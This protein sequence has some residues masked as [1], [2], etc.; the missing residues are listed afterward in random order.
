[1]STIEQNH[2]G[3]GDN[4]SG[5]KIYKIVKALAPDD[6]VGPLE[7]VFESLRKRDSV[8]AKIQIDM[9]RAMVHKE[10]ESVALLD[11]IAIYGSLID[12]NDHDSAWGTVANTAATTQSS[13]VKD[14][15]LAA[16]LRL[17]HGTD[18]EQAAKDHYLGEATPGQYA[19]EVF[20][21]QY[22]DEAYIKE[23]S[24]QFLISEASL[25]G[26]V[27]GSLRL[28]L[29][30][31]ANSMALRLSRDYPSY[32]AKVLQVFA[33]AY[34]LNPYV[35]ERH[36]WLCT[37]D[38]KQKVDQ[39]AEQVVEL[40]GISGDDK[41]L[42]N[43]ACPVFEAYRGMAPPHLLQALQKNINILEESHS[44]VAAA[45]KA[46]SGNDE[47]ISERL[48]G[49]LAAK[50]TPRDR[51][52]WCNEFLSASDYHIEDIFPFF[53][54]ATDTEIDEWLSRSPSIKNLSEVEE[55]LVILLGYSFREKKSNS[56][57][58]KRKHQL[59]EKADAFLKQWEQEL[60]NFTPEWIFELAENLILSDLP[61]KAIHFTSR[62]VPD[63]SLW[64]SPFVL[65][66]LRGL[67]EA[68]QYETF[69]NIIKKISDPDSSIS[70]LNFQSLKAER[71]GDINSAIAIS[72]DILGRAPETPYS[73]HRGCFLRSRHQ[74]TAQQ[75]DF[76][77]TIPDS[78]LKNYSPDALRILYFLTFSGNFKRAESHWVE[79]FIEDPKAR[80]VELVNFH[81]GLTADKKN[82]PEIVTSPQLLQC[83]AA[84]HFDQDGTSMTRLIVKDHQ[85]S[86]EFTLKSSSQLAQLLQGMSVGCSNELGMVSYTLLEKLDP[87]VACLRI[88]LHLRTIQNDGS[89][90]F[91]MLTIPSAQEELVPYLEKKL[92]PS[93]D[94]RGQLER[95]DL[96]LYIRGNFLYADNAFKSAMN[97]WSDSNIDTKRLFNQG[98]DKPNA[99]VLDAY[100]IAYLA[101]TDL[102]HHMLDMGIRFILPA[103]TKEALKC[104]IE[105]I[106]DEN[107]MLLGVNQNGKLF[108]TTAEDIRASNAHSL[109]ALRVILENATVEYPALHN[110]PLEIFSIR[111]GVDLTVYHAMQLS[112]ANRIPWFCMDEIF[113]S[114][115]YSNQHRTANVYALINRAIMSKPFEFE[116]RRHGLLLFSTGAIPLPVTYGDLNQL[117]KN[118]NRLAG[119]I[120]FK[121]IMNHGKEIFDG[122][123]KLELLLNLILLHLHA[124]YRYGESHT[125]L[126]PNY[127]LGAS[128]TSH[129]FNHGI[130][131]FLEAHDQG[132]C[133]SRLATALNYMGRRCGFNILFLR[134]VVGHFVE[135]AEGHFMDFEAIKAFL[136]SDVKD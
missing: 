102:A 34:E 83:V 115:H 66:H 14:V 130:M 53:R 121:I 3:S 77:K 20:L 112:I 117:A 35:S 73:W 70:I 113:S 99:V 45:I 6:L 32:N 26:I 134:Y 94:K 50:K 39:L 68:E 89:D 88:A 19:T 81:F 100:G 49:V 4:V 126:R 107:F 51:T 108:R 31:F 133:E 125:A 135:F 114:L 52:V 103:S 104:W 90:C 128:Y 122:N 74:N 41:R 82:R 58:L 42:Y 80:A 92:G 62:L 38:L 84:F 116:H 18:R 9:L 37:P 93:F 127:S 76:Q 24:K 23:A 71:M 48:R 43:I 56:D 65:T 16:L 46:A 44:S 2:S 30:S 61:N 87:Y 98:H 17:S 28:E 7:R 22:A 78:I 111:D 96:P 59:S 136:S 69:D 21:G 11:V 75:K 36:L 124:N 55:A 27:T 29:T 109:H 95:T 13:T 118:P 10:Q 106:S 33:R 86:N 123:D 132:N 101:V 64:A 131:L 67:L 1:M 40:I 110:I 57:N 120:F 12:E 85:A 105:E 15:C 91:A 97:C 63:H 54:L 60:N 72:D 47:N 79:W 129:V 119:F 25:T 8:T 5:D